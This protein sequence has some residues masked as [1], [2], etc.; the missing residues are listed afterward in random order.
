M[1]HI[2]ILTAGSRSVESN[3]SCSSTAARFLF[4]HHDERCTRREVRDSVQNKLFD[5]LHDGFLA[6][7]CLTGVAR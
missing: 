3:T 1:N 7:G 2:P 4:R 6:S 5:E